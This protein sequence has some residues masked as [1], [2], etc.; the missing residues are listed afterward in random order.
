MGILKLGKRGN[1]IFHIMAMFT[2]MAVSIFG[3]ATATTN[4][5]I[6]A[7]TTVPINMIYY[8]WH[9]D[10]ID[11]NIINKHPE[12]LV[13]N[14]P[15]GPWR[16][17]ASVSKFT[18]AGIK[19]LEYIDGGGEG[20]LKRSIP[21]DLKSNLNYI[22]A[23]AQ[24]GAYGI[25]VDEVC[26]GIYTT[27]N[28]SYLEQIASKAH[29][30]GLKVVF[31]TGVPNWAD[32]LMNYCDY[33]NSAENWRGEALSLSQVKWASRT[34]LLTE[35]VNDAATAAA[36]TNSALSKGI[37]AH[38]ATSTYN[39]LPSY[40]TAYV[41]QISIPTLTSTQPPVVAT[42]VASNI[43]ST[44]SKVSGNLT[45]TGTAAS[46]TVS[47]EYGTTTSYGITAAGVPPTLTSTGAFTA[48]LTGLTSGQTYH[49]RTKA[50]G[51]GTV[52]GN[53][54]SFKT[55][56]QPP[57]VATGIASN[58]TNTG[59]TVSG[60]LTST[61]TAASVTVS[62]E[63][64]TTTSYGSTAAGVP[65][66]LTSTGA[67]TANL[68]GL[69]SGQTYHFRTKAVGNGTV[70]GNDATFTTTGNPVTSKSGN[71]TGTVA[72][73]PV[74]T[75]AP[76]EYSLSL[77]IT[78]STVSGVTIGQLVWCAATTADF[79]NLLTV[80][81]TLTGTLDNSAGWWVLKA[82][83]IIPI[84]PPPTTGTITGSVVNV[85]V[86]TGG[87]NEYA[88]SIK[89]VSTSDSRFTNGQQVWCAATSTD[90]PNLLAVGATL[91]GTL[92]NS[93]GWWILKK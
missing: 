86:P 48:S 7:P 92:D 26:D 13:G 11:T 39:S 14:S 8:G 15:A 60:S 38:Y 21:N 82:S 28:Y 4:N 78:S 57:V 16:G 37:R 40:L 89:I 6:A 74:A 34:W 80:G 76:G 64:G 36:L 73:T 68:T 41:S 70:Y 58:V 43:T 12:F 59:A 25:F 47:F 22:A 61:G 24:A 81:A 35:N 33:I 63:Y 45:S 3:F 53:D 65:P 75:G 62:F 32:A 90:F 54:Q 85:P 18:S 19:Y 27:T 20:S 72:I 5:V 55:S 52:Y 51:N 29:S 44:G 49:F 91:T 88:L 69:S 87:F 9:N 56:T 77:R 42:G 79:P 71:T 10:T 84:P 1:I 83:T 30:L 17:N 50:V 31:N 93:V 2:L 46:V 23:A 66:T 67:F